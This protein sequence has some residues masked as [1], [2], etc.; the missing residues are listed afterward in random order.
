MGLPADRA[1]NLTDDAFYLGISARCKQIEGSSRRALPFMRPHL[2]DPYRTK[3]IDLPELWPE[4]RTEVRRA[5]ASARLPRKKV[6]G[7]DIAA[8]T[9]DQ[10]NI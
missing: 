5:F 3:K 8:G 1:L 9:H 2:I 4:R 7:A 10:V 6:G